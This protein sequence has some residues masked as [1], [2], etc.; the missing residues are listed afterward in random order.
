MNDALARAERFERSSERLAA[1]R[2]LDD[3]KLAGLEALLR[4]GV[5][6]DD[7]RAIDELMAFAERIAR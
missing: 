5:T 4:D 2:L 7:C 1:R 3:L 6:V